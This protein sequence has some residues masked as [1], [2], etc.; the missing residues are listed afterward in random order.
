[1]KNITASDKS[2]EDVRDGSCHCW[3]D[4]TGKVKMCAHKCDRIDD[5]CQGKKDE[6][7]CSPSDHTWTGI[8][9]VLV[10]VVVII[11]LIESILYK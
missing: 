7:G 6:M 11:L 4:L 8:G 10:I 5:G 9:V 1:M 3:D 2:C